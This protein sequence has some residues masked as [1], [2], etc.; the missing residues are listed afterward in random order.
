MKIISCAGFFEYF[1]NL[2]MQKTFFLTC[3]FATK[4]GIFFYSKLL[5]Y[6]FNSMCHIF[7]SNK[8]RIIKREYFFSTEKAIFLMIQKQCISSTFSSSQVNISLFKTHLAKWPLKEIHYDLW[9]ITFQNIYF[10]P[11]TISKQNSCVL[12]YFRGIWSHWNP[13][14]FFRGSQP[15]LC[16]ISA[17]L[18][19]FSVGGVPKLSSPVSRRL[20]QLYIFTEKWPAIKTNHLERLIPLGSM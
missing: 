17:S 8:I 1:C 20:L 13:Q 2:G 19:F 7:Q 4:K 9:H 6:N 16:N 18:V 12:I 10:Q 11:S 14:S 15:Q 5:N 3:R